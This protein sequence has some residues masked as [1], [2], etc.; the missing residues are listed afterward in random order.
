VSKKQKRSEI[1]TQA[2]AKAIDHMIL[3]NDLYPAW[4]SVLRDRSKEF[5][6]S[7]V[8]LMRILL[9]VE[10]QRGLLRDEL[11]RRIQGGLSKRW[12][13]RKYDTDNTGTVPGFSTVGGRPRQKY[14]TEKYLPRPVA[15]GE[16]VAAAEI[17]ATPNE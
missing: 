14:R 15:A 10:A 2:R 8:V 9:E 1:A 16:P 3:N 11:I 6:V 17:N 13:E 12:Y 7:R 4:R 5:G